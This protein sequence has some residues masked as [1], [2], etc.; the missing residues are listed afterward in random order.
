MCGEITPCLGRLLEDAGNSLEH[1][2]E[3]SRDAYHADAP[4]RVD[5]YG[6][7]FLCSFR[8][9]R[10]SASDIANAFTLAVPVAVDPSLKSTVHRQP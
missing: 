8:S 2:R 5:L 1:R 6:F 3:R 10:R 7:G 4:D 9:I